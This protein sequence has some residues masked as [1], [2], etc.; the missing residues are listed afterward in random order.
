M[1]KVY[2]LGS[3][4]CDACSAVRGRALAGKSGRCLRLVRTVRR[5]HRHVTGRAMVRFSVLMPCLNSAHYMPAALDT[6]LPQLGDDDELVVQD[7]G[8][9]D[10]TLEVLR[11]RRDD[12]IKL[13]SRPDGGQSAALAAALGRARG[14]VIGWLNAADTYAPEALACASRALAERPDAGVVIGSNTIFTDSRMIREHR[15]TEITRDKLLRYGCYVFSGAAFFR[16][17]T[18]LDAGGFRTDLHYCMDYELFLRLAEANVRSVVVPEVLGGLRWHDASK[19]GSQS[20]GFLREA[21]G[22]RAEYGHDLSPTRRAVL[23]VRHRALVATTALRQSRAYS[24]AR[25]IRHFR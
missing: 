23:T 8:S 14:D 25:G 20:A 12:R 10:G 13:V 3:C 2:S 18:L 5:S 21:A 16:R 24:A 15:P 7:G 9:T 11:E 6:V 22:L 4:A 17:H 1:G 19:S